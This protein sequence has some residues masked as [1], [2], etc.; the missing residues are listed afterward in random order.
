MVKMYFKVINSIIIALMLLSGA[1]SIPL[2]LYA[3]NTTGVGFFNALLFPFIASFY[4]FIIFGFT[5]AFSWVVMFKL[6]PN[7]FS[8]EINKHIISAISSIFIVLFTLLFLL[9][10]SISLENILRLLRYVIIVLPVTILSIY[11]YNKKYIKI[12]Y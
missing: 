11:I 6:L 12:K 9:Y 8:S 10:K 7:T 1:F 4:G 3:V 2:V 5:G